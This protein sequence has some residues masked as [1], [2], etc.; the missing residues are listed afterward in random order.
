[1]DNNFNKLT[2]T[3]KVHVRW[4]RDSGSS[5]V[6]GFAKFYAKDMYK[7]ANNEM[8]KALAVL[9]WQKIVLAMQEVGKQNWGIA[10][11]ILEVSQLT[12]EQIKKIDMTELDPE[13]KKY[14]N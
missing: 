8:E 14:S 3:M 1:M 12:K 5:R 4:F 10:N 13:L 6:L 11:D 9:W 2:I 7:Y